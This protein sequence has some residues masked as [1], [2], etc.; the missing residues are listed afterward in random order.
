VEELEKERSYQLS[1]KEEARDEY[2]SARKA[3]EREFQD[4][5]LALNQE[6]AD[7]KKSLRARV[8]QAV[9]NAEQA[10]VAD[11]VKRQVRSSIRTN[12]TADRVK[13]RQ[14]RQ[15][16]K[17]RLRAD[18]RAQQTLIDRVFKDSKGSYNRFS[19]KLMKA[20]FTRNIIP[21]VRKMMTANV[22]HSLTLLDLAGGNEEEPAAA[23]IVRD[24]G[25]KG[26][27][28]VPSMRF[29]ITERARSKVKPLLEHHFKKL[30]GD[31]WTKLGVMKSNMKISLVSAVGG[32]PH[33]GQ[34]ISAVVPNTVDDVYGVM[35]HAVNTSL[36]HVCDNMA[37]K[38]TETI[39]NPIM[40]IV[41]P[42]LRSGESLDSVTLPKAE[43]LA[44]FARQ[45]KLLQT[46]AVLANWGNGLK[47]AQA[48]AQ[49]Q[50]SELLKDA[51][52]EAKLTLA[53][54]RSDNDL[55]VEVLDA[56]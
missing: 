23:A 4:K 54:I 16:T 28:D 38:L 51:Y 47:H 42:K 40:D 22:Q 25:F 15:I 3:N 26:I 30:R 37:T 14:N 46:R 55:S 49:N 32:V 8:Q 24:Q 35:Q 36:N 33:V 39:A 27:Q 5:V 41:T 9:M 45:S 13:A 2:R 29:Y 1:H 20:R 52:D 50:E 21:K 34:T 11:W 6:H 10:H 12:M 31:L 18:R 44:D 19:R 48:E 17:R 43:E 7:S 53:D 56:Q